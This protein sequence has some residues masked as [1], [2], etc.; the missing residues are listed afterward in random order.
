MQNVLLVEDNPADIYLTQAALA[1]CD[2]HIRLWLVTNGLDALTFLRKEGH[3]IHAPS[4]ALI[5]LD[6]NLPRMHGTE[7]LAELRTLPTYQTT[8][9]VIFTSARQDIE[10]EHCLQLGATAYVRKPLD[11]GGFLAAIRAIID[12]WLPP[13]RAHS[14]SL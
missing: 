4:P 9:T 5:L 10:E 11:Y 6:I 12:H 14:G 3:Y 7:A 2:R 1:E 8:P 13:E